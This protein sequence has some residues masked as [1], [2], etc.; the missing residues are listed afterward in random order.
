MNT[1][2]NKRKLLKMPVD[3]GDTPVIRTEK[4]LTAPVPKPLGLRE[5]IKAAKSVA[6]VNDLLNVGA[7]YGHADSKTIHLW[8]QTASARITQLET[9]GV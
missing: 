4:P 1:H 7:G 6:E 5:Q 2:V 3:Y 9:E 8:K